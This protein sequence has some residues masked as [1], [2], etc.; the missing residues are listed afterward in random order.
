[1]RRLGLLPMRLQF[2]AADDGGAGGTGDVANSDMQDLDNLLYGMGTAGAGSSTGDAGTDTGTSDDAGTGDGQQDTDTQKPPQNT[3]NKQEYAFAQMRTQN[4][5]LFGLLAKVAQAA[6][7]EFKDNNELLNKLNDDA[8]GKLAKAQNVPVELL[9]RMEQLENTGKLYEAE[10]MKNTA[11]LGFQKVKDSYGLSDDELRSF[12]AEL[13]TKGKNPF[14]TQVDL[15]AE[16]K[17][18]HF[19]DIVK[20]ETQKA[21]EEALKKSNAADKHSSTPSNAQGKPDSGQGEK[22]T[23]VSGLND[24]LKDMK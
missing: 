22:I 24:I 4:T 13:D 16:Y 3:N 11:I 17:L 20:K 12:A 19:Q 14:L 6:G 10:Q 18:T 2:F 21:V 15:E 7:I 5:Q 23:T 8:L 1:M 9:K